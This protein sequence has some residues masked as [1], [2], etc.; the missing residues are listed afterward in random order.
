LLFISI[1]IGL[2]SGY[3]TTERVPGWHN[4]RYL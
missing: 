2:L 3:V 4:G 1:V